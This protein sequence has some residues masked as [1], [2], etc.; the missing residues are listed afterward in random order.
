[1]VEGIKQTDSI[2]VDLKMKQVDYNEAKKEAVR[3]KFAEKYNVPLKNVKVNFVPITVNETGEKISLASD[4]INNVHLPEFQVE[5]ERQWLEASDYKDV[6]FERIKAIDREV[7]AFIDFDAYSKYKQYKFKYVKWDNF[8]SY[9]KDNYFDFTKLHGLV[10]LNGSP[11]NQ[12]GKTTFAI[13]LLRF[14][15]FGKCDK[16][17]VLDR[18]FNAYLP[19]ETKAMVEACIE[20]DGV[21]Y[22]IRR[23]LERPA[24]SKRT[25]KSKIKQSVEYYKLFNG[26]YESIENCEGE[27]NTATSNII[28]EAVGSVDDFDLVISATS[29][30]LSNLL[31]M[32]QADKGRLFSKWLGLLTIEEKYE[33]AK[34]MWNGTISKGLWSNLYNKETINAEISN[35]NLCIDEN[36]RKINEQ[37]I[38]LNDSK[39]RLEDLEKE[40]EEAYKQRKPVEEGVE[41]LDVMTIENNIAG[42]TS[43]INEKNAILTQLV[44]EINKASGVTFSQEK[45]DSIKT[46][47]DEKNAE[48]NRINGLNGELRGKIF[49]LRE[50]NKRIEELMKNNVCP[51]CGHEIDVM[52]QAS[53]INKNKER[54]AELINEG[55]S[56]KTLIQGL[57]GSINKLNNELLEMEE[58]REIVSERQKKL[59]KKEA[60][61]TSIS[62]LNLSLEKY[63]TQK[64]QVEKNKENIRFNNEITNKINNITVTINNETTAH[65]NIVS[66]INNLYA[67]INAY[68]NGINERNG[69][70]TK[71]AEEEQLIKHWNIYLEMVGKNGISKIVLRNALPILNNEMAR[72]LD[73]ICDFEAKIEMDDKNNVCVNLYKDGVTMDLGTCSSGFEGTVTSLA[74]RSALG[75]VSSVSK[76]NMLVLDEILSGVAASNYDKVHELYNRIATN[77]SFIINITHNELISDWHNQNITIK[78]DGNVSTIVF[79]EH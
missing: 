63:E 58:N 44:L 32:G 65:N 20:I 18:A 76:S 41:N 24:L 2:V 64:K 72:L 28:K 37:N 68:N 70:L 25:A 71:L 74:L 47:I 36:N 53:F 43:Q 34:K 46:S 26:E 38:L 23:T 17:P 35:I 67:E 45:Y 40:K 42:V 8:L 66:E 49:S 33:Q 54:E 57:N 6:D 79:N 55:L 14:A 1:M 21:D 10:L 75:N 3:A 31:E 5:L 22:V 59:I 13:D 51:T 29:K 7:N 39:K 56:N 62:S 77:Y 78:K 11:E 61:E 52:E 19:K 69:I 12:C 50:D 15:L 48:I 30:T 73:G 60:V 4:I 27:S 9:G 16:A